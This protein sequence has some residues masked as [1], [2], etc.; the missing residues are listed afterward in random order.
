MYPC[1]PSSP[2]PPDLRP[3][4][5]PTT[6]TAFEFEPFRCGW[7]ELKSTEEATD[8]TEEERSQSESSEAEYVVWDGSEYSWLMG[9]SDWESVSSDEKELELADYE[10]DE[11]GKRQGYL[12]GQTCHSVTQVYICLNVAIMSTQWRK[13]EAF[14]FTIIGGTHWFSLSCGSAASLESRASPEKA[15]ER[16]RGG[17]GGETPTLFFRL[18]IFLLNF[19]DTE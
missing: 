13:S 5:N 14:I 18:N 10:S 11:Y 12:K 6:L 8:M 16:G 4:V 2:P 19:P 9:S 3:C 1:R 17:G 7:C 15:D